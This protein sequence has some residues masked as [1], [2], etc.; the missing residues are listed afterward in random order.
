MNSSSSTCP[1]HDHWV[2][3]DAYLSNRPWVPLDSVTL[4]TKTAAC[5]G[6][7][8][9]SR[10]AVS[11]EGRQLVLLAILDGRVHEGDVLLPSWLGFILGL[12]DGSPAR[13]SAFPFRRSGETGLLR[14]CTRLEIEGPL[15]SASAAASA[16][17]LALARP[18]LR[19]AVLRQLARAGACLVSGAVFAVHVAGQ[20]CAFRVLASEADKT[21]GLGVVSNISDELTVCTSA[22]IVIRQALPVLLS[23]MSGSVPDDSKRVG[24]IKCI[25]LLREIGLLQSR[26]DALLQPGGNVSGGL[27]LEV[28]PGAAEVLQFLMHLRHTLEAE[29]GGLVHLPFVDFLWELPVAQNTRSSS[30][31]LRRLLTGFIHNALTEGLGAGGPQVLVLWGLDGATP[32]SADSWLPEALAPLRSLPS[33]CALLGLCRSRAQVLP[34]LH[35]LFDQSAMSSKMQDLG[36][37][38]SC[39]IRTKDDEPSSKCA[40]VPVV[41]GYHDALSKLRASIVNYFEQ[42]AL[43]KEMGADWPPRTLLHGPPG[44]GKTFLLRWLVSQLPPN[45]R[46]SWLHPGEVLSRYVG[47]SEER[48]RGA[49]S[50]ALEGNAGAGAVLLLE[51]LDQLAPHR[52]ASTASPATPESGDGWRD[53]LTAALLLCLDGV[54]GRSLATG[55]PGLAVVATSSVPAEELDSRVTRPGRMDCW[56]ALGAPDA[57]CRLSLIQH[58]VDPD[59]ELA[60]RTK[61]DRALPG[62]SEAEQGALI[63][64]SNGMC[65]G[66]LKRATAQ[67]MSTLAGPRSMVDWSSIAAAISSASGQASTV[68]PTRGCPQLGTSPDRHLLDLAVETAVPDDDDDL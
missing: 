54:D 41:V 53:R 34:A 6:I 66:R 25:A 32:D 5:L 62:M 10:V 47:E 12:T 35:A 59:L 48:L 24:A 22:V 55:G 61:G 28:S 36:L 11:V 56:V 13:V 39:G 18:D 63:A 26:N 46:T 43:F 19:A 4:S 50:G 16:P 33:S 2:T 49:F 51:G 57:E 64:A 31:I 60:A 42:P 23:T 45:V 30:N 7:S 27:L 38:L 3:V 37:G 21:S 8:P 67:A 40:P 65:A 52:H 68:A 58:F 1:L 20:V 17:F 14:P 29:G 9:L 44:C 15:T